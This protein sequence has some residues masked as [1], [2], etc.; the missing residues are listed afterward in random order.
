[1]GK[2]IWFYIDNY[3]EEALITLFMSYFTIA[4]VLTVLFRHVFEIS[5]AWTDETARYSFIW[6]MFIGSAV[7]AK[8][9]SHISVDIL[10]TIIKNEKV[11]K[12][13][14]Q[15]VKIVFLVFAI[16]TT[17]IGIQVSSTLITFPQRS[18][19][20]QI[21]MLW[22]FISMP[23]GMGLT[24][25]RIIQSFFKKPVSDDAISEDGE[26]ANPSSV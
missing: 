18:P 23:I 7:A 21:S 26:I 1:M 25:L 11:R 9:G 24:S 10:Q 5:A 6:M 22:V 3:F 4:V 19:V 20:L 16:I 2:K 8:K 12:I 14:L 15:I 13:H 17:I